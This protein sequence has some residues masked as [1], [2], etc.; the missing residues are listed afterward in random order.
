MNMD[1]I[2]TKF[3]T[4]PIKELSFASRFEIHHDNLIDGY[5]FVLGF[6]KM[7]LLGINTLE[8]WASQISYLS[9]NMI[10]AQALQAKL[11]FRHIK[12]AEQLLAY[13]MSQRFLQKGIDN[14]NPNLLSRFG[15]VWVEDSTCVKLI[16]ELFE[17][18][19]GTVNASGANSSARIQLR[20]DI[21]SGAFSHVEL[22]S[23]RD[24]DQKFSSKILNCLKPFDLVIRD[25]GYWNLSVFNQ[26]IQAQAYLISRLFFNAQV[27]DPETI[28]QIDLY[29]KLRKLRR[30]GIHTLDMRVL[31]GKKEKLP[32]R[33]IAIKVPQNIE[34]QRKR[35]A[36]EDRRSNRSDDYMESLAWTIF[37]TNVEE[38]VWTP[39]QA[40]QVYGF[41][42]H[43]EIIFKC[44]K[45]KFGLV[46]LFEGKNTLSPPR[47]Y[48]TFYLFLVW[49][50][51]FFA[52]LYNFYL[53]HIYKVK[54]KILSLFKFADF[55]KQYSGQLSEQEDSAWVI[56]HLAKY[57]S[58]T[59]RK[60]K[61]NIEIMYMLNIT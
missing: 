16:R 37:V 53:H 48:I 26:I 17:F 44:W 23:Y 10:S 12:F 31:V 60:A 57:C 51:L 33:L 58:M 22:Q 47:V 6:F 4:L 14:L 15:R 11:Q 39:Q 42:W 50:T 19:P 54:G 56:D 5:T 40:L 34:Q 35:K 32:M 38:E 13:A 21:K 1:K 29:K 8:N 28:E 36:N 2:T 45:S 7:L 3:A 24:N 30:Q 55:M 49:I 43:I 59:K 41:R 20:L 61:S 18:F 9:G 25:L 52:R 27:F 46:K